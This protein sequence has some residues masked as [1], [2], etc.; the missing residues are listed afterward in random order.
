MWFDKKKTFL[1]FSALLLFI[2]SAGCN[3]ESGETPP[4]VPTGNQHT[5][6]YS[7]GPNG[8]IEGTGRQIV[9]HGD[10]G[11][12]V[13]AVPDGGYHFVKWSDG[14]TA[15]PRTDAKVTTDLEVKATFGVDQ[16]TL[17]YVAGGHGSIDGPSPQTVDHGST[18][19]PVTAIPETGYHFESWSDGSTANPRT[20][21]DVIADLEVS[22]TFALNQYTLTY[23]AGANGSIDGV[24]SQT[25]DHGGS[26]SSV[27]AVPGENFHFTGW[28]DGVATPARTDSNVTADISVTANF[29]MD[30][31]TLVYTAGA[32]GSIGGPGSQKVNRGGTGKAVRAVPATG[33][34]FVGWSDGETANPRTDANVMADLAVTAAFELNRYTLTYTAGEN[35]SIEGSGQQAVDHGGEGSVVTAVP[36][37]GFHFER[38]SDGITTASR[39]DSEVTGDFAVSAVFAVN[40]YTV[41]GTLSGLTKGT[42]LVLQNNGGDD[43][44]L[45][46]NGDFTFAGE[47]LDAGSYAVT[48]LNQPTSP[49]QT[50]TVADGAGTIS[51]ENVPD[52]AVT[53]VLNTYTI[54]GRV[55]GLPDGDRVVLQYN[56]GDNLEIRTNG[57]FT[58]ATPLDD[59]SGY[60]ITVQ[61]QPQ[62]ANWTC[63]VENAVGALAGK[64]V[65]DVDVSC[66][67]EAVLQATAGIHKVEVNWN[68]QDFSKVT[69][70]LCRSREE[71]DYSSCQDLK[72][73]TLEKNVDSPHVVS[74]LTNDIPY[75]FLV[76]VQHPGGRRTLSNIVKATPFGGLNDSGIDWCANDIFNRF[77]DGTRKEKT[78][79]CKAVA[80]TH[81]GQDALHGRDASARARKLSKTG[82]GSA[83]FDFTKLCRSGDA[84]GDGKCPPNPS[85]GIGRNNWACT[86]D[87]V[88]GLI[89]EVKMESGLQGRDNTYSWFNPDGTV[90]G[91][92]PGQKNGGHCEGSACDT[93]GY[94]RAVNA[95][96]LCGFSDWR[97][98]TRRELLSIVDNGRYKP[99]IDTRSFPNTPAAYYWSSTP[100]ADHAGSAWEVYFHYGE[101]DSEEKSHGNRVRLVHGRTVTF[102][103]D[104]P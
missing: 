52:I 99:A 35:G 13:T 36:D 3:K 80:G 59:G 54:G 88:T 98:P 76:E 11:S 51:G 97:L 53:C 60:D 29:G 9:D 93:E 78:G 56:K 4:I 10:A 62:K 79:S 25:V 82:Y 55:S 83:G 49:N 21:A 50:C 85:P 32:N 20:D 14:S 96:G 65:T 84:A 90:N 41:G 64:N 86:R 8:V 71:K 38:W 42:R 104:N 23:V 69:F 103:L 45:T 57:A 6:T 63:D 1:C 101:T 72:E 24:T 100:Y 28:S 5:L 46:A 94:V 27:T 22:A 26:G 7:A 91:G 81:P 18:G 67:L 39:T 102:G 19:T 66:Y 87:N 12:A 47:L 92:N 33:F 74:R 58:F 89:W 40:T 61:S 31:F 75:W 30:Q 77:S 68:S 70:N 2:L 95:Q 16:Y 43:L 37:K 17:S 44:T 34:H 48:V 15:N 73:G